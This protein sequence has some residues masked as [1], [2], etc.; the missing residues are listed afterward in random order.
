MRKDPKD[1]E[2]S[3]LSRWSR[4][5]TGIRE[6]VAPETVEKIL[7][8]PSA[9]ELEPL[10]SQTPVIPEEPEKILTDE[11]MPDIETLDANSDYSVFMSEGVSQELRNLA[12]R[13]MFKNPVF[14][15]R[16][17]LDDYDDDFTT[18][19]NL[20]DLVT[21]DMRHR[22][23]MKEKIRQR[24]EEEEAQRLAREAPEDGAVEKEV[25]DEE[26]SNEPEESTETELS[27]V[28]DPEDSDETKS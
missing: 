28:S 20:G 14:N 17:G 15:V 7:E 21:A 3:F 10:E 26:E 9:G 2:E 12:L 13:K 4:R 5:K 24:E 16:D 25:T 22:E 19:A 23:E 27:E 18:F 1:T 11:D 8:T 6:E